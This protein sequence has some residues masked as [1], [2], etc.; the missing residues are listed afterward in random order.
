MADV[1]RRRPTGGR[2]VARNVVWNVLAQASPMLVALVCFPRLVAELGSSSFGML[3]LLWSLLGYFGLF[4]LGL[5]RALTQMVAAR[6]AD[7]HAIEAVARTVRTGLIA[8]AVLGSMVA[9]LFAVVVPGHASDWLGVPTPAAADVG[10]AAAA[11]APALACVILSAALRGVLEGMQWFG[12]L[13]VIRSV[14]ATAMFAVPTLLTFCRQDLYALA[15]SLTFV[16]FAELGLLAFACAQ[17]LPQVLH[18]A[19]VRRSE[20]GRLLRVGS[21]MTVSNVVG[22]L[23][24]TFDRFVIAATLSA[25]AAAYYAAPYEVVTRLLILPGALAGVLLPG[26]ASRLFDNRPGAA[27]LYGSGVRFA[28]L[29]VLL[30]VVALVTLAPELLGFWLGPDFGENG[31]LVVRLLA[32]GVLLNAAAQVPFALL[33]GAGLPQITARL[34]LIELPFYVALLLPLISAFGIAGAALT[35]AIRA[36]IDAALLLV[37]AGRSLPDVARM[38]ANCVVL[39]GLAGV[40]VVIGWSLEGLVPKIAFVV[41]YAAIAVAVAWRAI[42]TGSEREVARHPLSLISGSLR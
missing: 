18:R 14:A 36:S 23:M 27:S 22:P 26:F 2:A 3:A 39:A 4:D 9:V 31:A 13:G 34:H 28:V 40:G 11:V 7:S 32:L 15:L 24:M 33:Q 5:G 8:S 20:V 10:R 12:V 37:I 16:R 29:S 21:W 17:A 30:P 42:L 6:L 41:V 35:W 38:P 19:E 25:A 1:G